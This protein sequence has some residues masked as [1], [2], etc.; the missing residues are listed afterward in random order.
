MFVVS[1]SKTMA[2]AKRIVVDEGFQRRTPRR[3]RLNAMSRE[4]E[5]RRQAKAEEERQAKKQAAAIVAKWRRKQQQI[6][7]PIR[8]EVA[9][10]NTAHGG[11][12]ARVAFWHGL[13]VADIMGKSRS[14]IIVAARHDAIAAVY[15][16]CR[17]EGR[18]YSRP[19]LGQIFGLDHTTCL[20]ALRKRGL[21]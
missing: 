21:A 14:D 6:K 7:R 15:L 19:K 11:I 10:V 16:N 9:E 8:I 12:I 18:Q 13:T 5:A 1:Y 20:F 4:W 17:I 2:G 3:D